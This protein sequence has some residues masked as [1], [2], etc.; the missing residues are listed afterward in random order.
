MPSAER[1]VRRTPARRIGTAATVA[2]AI[3]CLIAPSA[4]AAKQA[5]PKPPAAHT[6]AAETVSYASATLKG[7]LDPHGEATYYYFQYG[8][9]VSYGGQTALAEAGA[10]TTA[11]KVSAPI[12]GLSPLTSYHYRL[13]AVSAA[14]TTLGEDRKLMTSK[15]PLSLQIVASPNPVAYGGAITIQGTLSGTGAGNR[16]V[17]L[18]ANAYPFTAGFV[19]VGNVELTSATGSF[20]FVLLNVGL[21]TEYKV[22]TSTTPVVESPVVPEGVSVLIHARHHAVKHDRFVRVK[23]TVT[24]ALNGMHIGIMRLRKGKEQLVKGAVLH[25]DGASRSRFS[26]LIPHR[27]K[28]LY[29]VLV[30]VSSGAESGTYGAP[31]QVH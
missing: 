31:F 7:S 21:I 26:T 13:V 28:D 27:A 1:T 3:L 19:N 22:V 5:K 20:S 29:N 9:T 14:G 8:P 6:G 11:I 24:P 17:V 23:G 30:V 4:I 15:V 18:Q 12:E 16:E 25:A 10:G 2:C